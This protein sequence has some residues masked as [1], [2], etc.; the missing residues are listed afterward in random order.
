MAQFGLS[1]EDALTISK[2][3]TEKTIMGE[4]AIK[5]KDG[6]DGKDGKDGKSAYQAALDNGFIGTEV[7]WLESLKGDKG[8]KGEPGV[9]GQDG[10]PGADGKSAYQYAKDGGYTGTETE[11]TTN[12]A[13]SGVI[14]KELAVE[15]ARIDNL[16]TLQDGST[17]GDAELIDARIDKDGNT[18]VNVGEH[19]R[20]VSSQLSSEITDVKGDLV[21]RLLEN[22]Y[23]NDLVWNQGA[24]NSQTGEITPS[25]IVIYSDKFIV[26]PKTKF[27]TSELYLFV[28]YYDNNDG[29]LGGSSTVGLTEYCNPTFYGYCRVAI[30]KKEE[31]SIDV[32]YGNKLFY[33]LENDFSDLNLFDRS[34]FFET[35]GYYSVYNGRFVHDDKF[36]STGLIPVI[37]GDFIVAGEPNAV[38]STQY[39]FWNEQ[40][41][42]VTGISSIDGAIVPQNVKFVRIPTNINGIS[43][44]MLLKG[45]IK[46]AFIGRFLFPT[47]YID[48]NKDISHWNNKKWYAYGTSIT[49]TS[50]E[51]KYAFFVEQKGKLNRV[52]KGI[53][54]GGICSNTSIKNAVMNNTDGKVEADLITLEVTAN[55]VDADLGVYTDTSDNTFCG[56]LH[57]CIEYLQRNTNAQ[58]VVISSPITIETYP[59]SEIFT[60][61]YYEWGN[62]GHTLYDMQKA[63]CEV[64]K[65]HSVY[66]IN[67]G[68]CSN[69]SY[70]RQ[71]ADMS[72]TQD[73]VH[74][75]DKGGYILAN[76]IWSEL[77]NIPYFKIN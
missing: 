28:A 4:G 21:K 74:P 64:C 11:F 46:S 34:S 76:Y 43:E 44:F 73:G 54:G 53:S 70:Y 9:P 3:Y 35:K 66:Y 16:T 26:T 57:Q 24:I 63:I 25:D 2:K 65:L 50:G 18:H 7:E 41:E 1:A 10:A 8:D 13:R 55:D 14:S 22:G 52:N 59:N 15:R 58:I 20:T 32:S 31:T 49:N 19:I 68:G 60:D 6:A 42:F 30:W 37:P 12:I 45:V 69:F 39:T 62:D 36:A 72:L 29:Y 71:R 61:P 67:A 38:Y 33:K 56:A 17:T 5:G 51:G 75:S 23:K 48:G 47:M 77:K 40:G 27:I